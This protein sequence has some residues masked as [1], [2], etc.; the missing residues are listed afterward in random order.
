M[1]SEKTVSAIDKAANDAVFI[2][3]LS[4]PAAIRYIKQEVGKSVTRKEA[5]K[6]IERTVIAYKV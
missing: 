5:A 6:A 4:T 1:N 2:H 3:Q